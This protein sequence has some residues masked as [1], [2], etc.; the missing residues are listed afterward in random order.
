[1]HGKLGNRIN[2]MCSQLLIHMCTLESIANLFIDHL[3]VISFSSLLSLITDL[4]K[5]GNVQSVYLQSELQLISEFKATC[6]YVDPSLT[7][8]ATKCF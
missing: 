4:I 2:N 8:I 7:L 5:R 6:T 3:M 1:M